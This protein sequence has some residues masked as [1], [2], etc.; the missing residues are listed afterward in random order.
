MSLSFFKISGLLIYIHYNCFCLDSLHFFGIEKVLGS[1]LLH[2]DFDDIQLRFGLAAI[3]TVW[4]LE[5]GHYV[6]EV[7]AYVWTKMGK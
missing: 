5:T 1:E 6:W 2:I 3:A 4:K 7:L